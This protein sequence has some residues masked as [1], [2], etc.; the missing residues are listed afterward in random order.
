M[1]VRT[2][3]YS[4]AFISIGM[5]SILAI[6]LFVLS[7]KVHTELNKDLLADRF[8]DAATSIIIL[9]HEYTALQSVRTM[10]MLENKLLRMNVI[11]QEAEGQ[12]PLEII[13]NAFKS[14]NNTYVNLKSIYQERKELIKAN[15]G[16]AEIDRTVY[17]EEAM[18]SLLFS[19]SHKIM[20]IA[21]RIATQARNE[22]NELQT[23]GLLVVS[24]FSLLLIVVIGTS[25]VLIARG[26]TTS[27]GLLKQSVVT[28]SSGNLDKRVP[29]LGGD[30]FGDLSRGFETM[31]ISRR[32]AES[33][34]KQH[35]EHLE[36]LVAQRTT[37]LSIAKEQ[38]EAANRVKS[39][40][41]ASMSHEL[42]TPL[43]SIIGFTGIILNEL[44]GP[45]NLEQKKQLKMVKGSS[46]HLLNLIN[47]VLDIS[48]IEAGEMEVSKEEFSIRQVIAQV[49]E[50]L[51]PLAE[52]K[53][54]S[55]SSEI[56]PEVD[57][58]FSDERRIR[59][60]LI[61]LV[62]NAIKFTEK[63]TVKII[64]RR[65]DSRIEVQVTDTGI[66]IRNEDMGNLFKP[67]QQL[68]TGTSRRF[69]GTGLGL[70]ICKRILDMLGGTIR[71]KSQ[72]GKYTTFIFTLPLNPEENNDTKKDPD[73]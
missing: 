63:G 31:R 24:G 58:L 57:C 56:A 70:S 62:N 35:R 19:E 6:S 67:F 4:A 18:A 7:F 30:E 38:A 10:N 27:L 48:K 47:D 52:Q 2:K 55:L 14:L 8:H 73:R 65:Q 36:D 17:L 45:L 13:L 25:V 34:L 50:S 22:T 69:E 64:C 66:G 68:D 43:N 33:E 61:N 42:R 71:V 11:I 12:I 54:L 44:T 59:Q 46:H 28:I 9:A 39:A 40:F 3:L 23:M 51:L 15:A 53:D 37:D 72:F 1:K 26:I 20:A 49:V 16:R 32:Q 5:L 41:L 60:I 21:T 29:N